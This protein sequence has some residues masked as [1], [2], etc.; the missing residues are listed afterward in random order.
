MQEFMYYEFLSASEVLDNLDDHY[1]YVNLI[2]QGETYVSYFKDSQV[3]RLVERESMTIKDAVLYLHDSF[4]FFQEF[5]ELLYWNGIN[6]LKKYVPCTGE[7]RTT[8]GV[9]PVTEDEC[10]FAK[11]EK[12][13]KDL[14]AQSG[15]RG[16]LYVIDLDE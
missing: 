16:I 1:M 2:S 13:A 10:V 7:I 3:Q 8:E 12:E 5:R 4:G 11:N 6:S 9:E 14:F 15:V